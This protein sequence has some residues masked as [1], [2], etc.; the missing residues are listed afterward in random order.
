[1]V[2]RVLLFVAMTSLAVVSSAAAQV[3]PP[4]TA[5]NVFGQCQPFMPVPQ[6]PQNPLPYTTPIPESGRFQTTNPQFPTGRI[7]VQ[8][9]RYVICP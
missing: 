8:D 6:Q 7:C 4:G 1:M 2:I 3:C 9:G 5:P